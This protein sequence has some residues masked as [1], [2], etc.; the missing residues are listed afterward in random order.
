[1][2]IRRIA[3]LLALVCLAG[4]ERNHYSIRM[5]PADDHFTR[6]LTC[7]TK[8]GS[9][10]D[11]ADASSGMSPDEL[12]IL[13]L[14]YAKPVPDAPPK[15]FTVSGTF[16][17][18]TPNDVGGSG[19]FKIYR[20]SLGTAYVYM[21]QF[22]GNDNFAE[23]Q[24]RQ[25]QAVDVLVDLTIEWLRS[26]LGQEPGFMSLQEFVDSNIRRDVR[27]V[28]VRAR[29]V[30]ASLGWSAGSQEHNPGDKPKIDLEQLVNWQ[31]LMYLKNQGY[32][33]DSDFAMVSWTDHGP[34]FTGEGIITIV[35]RV[36]GERMG[37][38]AEK[39]AKR[40]GFLAA[41]DAAGASMKKFMDS[42]GAH[43]LL[44]A[45]KSKSPWLDA[46]TDMSDDD[47]FTLLAEQTLGFRILQNFDVLDLRLA[48]PVKPVSTNGKWDTGKGEIT[49]SD[50]LDISRDKPWGSP[51][52]CY[53][54][55]VE[56]NN[57][58]Q[59]KHLGKLRMLT[60]A[61]LLEY[62]IW[63]TSLPLAEGTQWDTMVASLDQGKDVLARQKKIA[64]F[65]FAPGSTIDPARGIGFLL[66]PTGSAKREK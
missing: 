6:E 10:D 48:C 55:W 31:I 39:A 56:P 4:C 60:G 33:N 41:Q 47:T 37:M 24:A 8:R 27:N 59:T 32:F 40:L 21:E 64:E 29:E 45:W 5:S 28:A 34:T 61:N 19:I 30:V 11:Q 50:H 38:D 22:R 18:T 3:I 26:E 46:P 25:L 51:V 49:W 42:G 17:D 44:T 58:A 20:T 66:D 7:E 57:A 65:K 16:K 52:A 15:K 63:R 36:I 13:A 43:A 14:A 35:R 23:Q 53:A 9:G 62:A 12:K 2:F 1:M 54:A